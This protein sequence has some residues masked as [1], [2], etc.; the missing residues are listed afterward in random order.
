MTT[1]ARSRPIDRRPARL[2]CALLLAAAVHAPAQAG[3]IYRW[4]D[5]APNAVAG[6][7]T[8][9]LEFEPAFWALGSPFTASFGGGGPTPAIPGL[10]RFY[11]AS[12][13]S[14]FDVS[15]RSTSPPLFGAYALN[16]VLTPAL[17]GSALFFDTGTDTF[18]SSAVSASAPTTPI[19]R[20]DNL[21]SDRSPTCFVNAGS[22][23][24]GGT[25]QWLLDTSTVPVPEPPPWA[26]L[27]AGAGALTWQ[28][29]AGRR[30]R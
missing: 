17:T 14:G 7:S 2:L 24:A 12:S 21:S 1:L 23:C 6:T 11:F 3:V 18:G 8:G 9:V 22:V 19:W 15:F 29:L 28:R 4:L 27:A 5:V 16:L 26:L 10:I 20:I 30:A 13:H 25:G